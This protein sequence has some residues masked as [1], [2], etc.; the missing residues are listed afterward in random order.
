MFTTTLFAALNA[1]TTVICMGYE[2]D[3]FDFSSHAGLVRLDCGEDV[4]AMFQDGPVQI[5]ESGS[6]HVQCYA[7][8]EAEDAGLD[9]GLA[10]LEF[11]VSIPLTQGFIEAAEKAQ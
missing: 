8:Q 11:R 9:E 4:I 1:A 6:C 3:N 2:I 5:D 7:G 10:H